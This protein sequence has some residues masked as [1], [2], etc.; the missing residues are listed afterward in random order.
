MILKNTN[1]FKMPLWWFVSI[2]KF[3][4]PIL[5]IIFFGLNLYDLFINNNGTYSYAYWAEIVGG[6]VPM[7][8]CLL[9]GIVV[10]MIV[11]RK[12]KQGFEEDNREWDDFE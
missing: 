8:L 1:K 12:K 6:W 5:L 9:S 7:I 3:I 11:S 10:K 4:A 2:I